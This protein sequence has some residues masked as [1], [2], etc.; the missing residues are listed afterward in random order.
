MVEGGTKEV[1]EFESSRTYFQREPA[2]LSL[3]PR[4]EDSD[5]GAAVG[6]R[7]QHVVLTDH[8]TNLKKPTGLMHQ[9][10]LDNTT[11]FQI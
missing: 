11:G 7:L 5:L 10:R 1:P 2:L 3:T 6:H 9:S 8:Q 4:R